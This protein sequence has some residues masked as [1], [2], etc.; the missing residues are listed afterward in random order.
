[1][2]EA[3]VRAAG[4]D[5]K[6]T[7]LQPLGPPGLGVAQDP[8]TG[9]RV[10]EGSTVEIVVSRGANRVEVTDVVGKT[11]GR[12]A[13]ALRRR[14]GRRSRSPSRRPRPSQGGDHRPGSG[15]RG[16]G[17]RAGHRA[18]RR[19]EG[20]RSQARSPTSPGSARR[21]RVPS[22]PGGP[23]RRRL[24]HGDNDPAVV[25]G[26]VISTD[27]PAGTMVEK[28]RAMTSSCRRARPRS[29]CPR[30]ATSPYQAAWRT[31]CARPAWSPTWWSPPAGGT[32]R[33]QPGPRRRDRRSRRV[34][35]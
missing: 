1:M 6:V 32:H 8:K 11:L 12:G 25:V 9:S 18:V 10:R 30:S 35:R 5:P 3:E 17:H 29:R 4:L 24:D 2:A 23:G 21:R 20:R 16:G 22:R 14:R 15:A 31:R 33:D 13:T 7:S 27:P 26:A 19:V 34:S 28:D